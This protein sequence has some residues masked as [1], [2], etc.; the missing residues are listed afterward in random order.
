MTA[1]TG[2][3]GREPVVLGRVGAPHGVQGWVKV[4]S[5]TEP[6]EGITDYPEW[7]VVRGTEVRRMTVLESKRAGQGIAVRLE[8]IETREAAQMLSGA[9][10]RIDR[11]ELPE[12]GPGEYYWHDLVG[13]EASN[14][15]G[16][17]LGRVAEIL[18]LPAHPVI[19]LRGERERLVPL[20]PE[21][22]VAVDLAGGKLTLDWHPDD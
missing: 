5:Y 3:D 16:Q 13:L 10:V 11:S 14:R 17:S 21:R 7:D 6:P 20:V 18:E 8:G 15:D 4:F 2:E 9:E 1:R 12:A 22:L 19:V